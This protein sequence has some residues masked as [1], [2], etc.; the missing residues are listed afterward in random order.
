V[1]GL[2]ALIYVGAARIAERF[3]GDSHPI[4]LTRM[5]GLL[6][7]ALAIPVQFDLQWVTLG[8]ALLAL[9]L[10]HAGLAA[11]SGRGERW[12]GYA[13]LLLAV[14]RTLFWDTFAALN[15]LDRYRP[16]VNGNFLVASQRPPLSGCRLA[17]CFERV[18]IWA[19][20]SNGLRRRSL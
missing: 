7:A 8:W 1:A 5:S 15:D 10:Q 2:L 18:P 11:K 6:L 16:I 19:V 20:S 9:V 17:W 3:R 14:L 12:M 4:A 13:V